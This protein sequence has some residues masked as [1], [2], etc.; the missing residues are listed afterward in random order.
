MPASQWEQD[1]VASGGWV[2]IGGHS[3]AE[4]AMAAYRTPTGVVKTTEDEYNEGALRVEVDCLNI[5]AGSGYAPEVIDVIP[6]GDIA[7]RPRFATVQ[8]DAGVTELPIVD[9]EKFRRQMVKLVGA[10]R[11][12]GLRHGDLTEPNLVF[13]RDH[14]TLL[15]WQESHPLEERGPQKQPWTDSFMAMRD[16]AGIVSVDGTFDTP[17]V[18]RRWMAVLT[19]LGATIHRGGLPLEGKTFVD[20]GCYVGDFP[21]LAAIEGMEAWG[22]DAGGFRTGENSIEIGNELW[23]DLLPYVP[24]LVQSDLFDWIFEAARW[25]SDEPQ[26]EYRPWDVSMMFSTYPYLVDQRGEAAAE[27]LVREIIHRSEVFYFETQ[28][29]GDGPG[30]Q[31]MTEAGVGH[32][33][34]GFVPGGEVKALITIP[35][36]GRPASRTVFAVRHE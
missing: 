2:A 13:R 20:L 15:D 27:G 34:E 30:Q 24:T 9:G 36:W 25:W 33:L 32:W 7:T 11:G 26:R 5:M 31:F 6:K 23:H 22:V 29:V 10:V 3:N 28:L 18:A 12:R 17:R 1:G 21:A 19:D 8:T 16:V 35:V 14:P 4:G